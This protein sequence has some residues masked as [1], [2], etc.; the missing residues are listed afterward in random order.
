MAIMAIYTADG[1][2]VA[3]Y[4]RI[5]NEIGWEA[6]PP[7]GGVL[8][9]LGQD[10]FGLCNLEIWE[11]EAAFDTYVRERFM[12]AFDRLGMPYPPAPRVMAVYNALQRADAETHIRRVDAE[13]GAYA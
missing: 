1:F 3:E 5:R 12:P 11:S 9:L 13:I 7:P 6:D 10:G 4:D 8:H 2:G